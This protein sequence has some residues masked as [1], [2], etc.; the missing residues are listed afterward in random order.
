MELRKKEGNM[1]EGHSDG[2]KEIK[3]MYI[4]RTTEDRVMDKRERKDWR[5]DRKMGFIR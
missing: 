5:K 3:R 2:I 1:N 4:V